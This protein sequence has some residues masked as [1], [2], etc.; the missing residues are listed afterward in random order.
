MHLECQTCGA[1]L[2]VDPAQR[3]ALCPYCASPSVVERPP[4]Q[5]RP[6]P[7]FVLG[8]TMTREGAH[9]AVREWLGRRGFFVQSSVK[10][11]TVDSIRGVYSPAYLYSAMARSGYSAEIG[12]NYQETET[13]TTTDDKGN[14]VVRTRTVTKTEWRHL[15]G[16]HATYVTDVLVTA[17]RAVHNSELEAIE[18]FDLRMMRRYT[19]AVISGWIAEEPTLTLHDCYT[20]ARGEA[21]ERIGRELSAFMPGDSHRGL[22]FH[23]ALDRETTD[24]IY[25][26]IWALAIRHDPKRPP[27]RVLING[28]TG[29]IWGKAP[30][31]WIKITLVVL[32]VL[33]A[34]AAPF[35][36]GELAGSGKPRNSSPPPPPPPTAASPPP[37]RPPA[38]TK[39]PPPKPTATTKS[40]A[41]KPT[42]PTPTGVKR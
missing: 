17:S 31:S 35:V 39:P 11:G 27:F 34:I 18:P 15:S 13:Y 33:L 24:L 4:S 29:K 10:R 8:F 30:L 2:V 25:V 32:L 40:T 3:T 6:A 21:T 42:S 37:T 19:P 26:P 20:L 7:A 5:D 12:E 41:T 22:S 23:T 38:T 16:E 36:I 1:S 9:G 14:T 28:Q